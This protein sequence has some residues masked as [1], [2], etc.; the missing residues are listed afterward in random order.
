MIVEA[1]EILKN[2]FW[3]VESEGERVGTLSVSED[4]QYMLSDTTGTKFF[5][6]LKQ[7]KTSFGADI[8]WTSVQEDVTHIDK[9]V[10]GFPASCTPYNPMFDVKQK[11]ALFTKSPKSKSLYCAGYYIIKFDKGW[12]KSFCPKL[13]TV[14]R[15][16]TKGP[17]KSELEMRQALSKANAR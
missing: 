16:E 9:E 6:N 8:S 13:I 11:L 14:E 17:F 3:I 12:V 10:H 5:S 7:L 4:K 15:Y 2:K 1:K